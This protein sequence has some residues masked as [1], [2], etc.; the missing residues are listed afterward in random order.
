MPPR[1]T[2]K[3]YSL[4]FQNFGFLAHPTVYCEKLSKESLAEAQNPA[5]FREKKCQKYC[6]ILIE[7][8]ASKNLLRQEVFHT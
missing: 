5:V 8:T 1:P 2:K 3:F 7:D 4:I 6:N